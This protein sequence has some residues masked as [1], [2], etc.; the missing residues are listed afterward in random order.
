MS[1]RI[2]QGPYFAGCLDIYINRSV[3]RI[4]GVDVG[5]RCGVAVVV[6]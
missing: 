6:P 2:F 4:E 1:C 3:L 5:A